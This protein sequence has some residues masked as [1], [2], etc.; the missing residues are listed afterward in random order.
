ML[1]LPLTSE[2]SKNLIEDML[3]HPQSAE[4]NEHE[5]AGYD[6]ANTYVVRVG[7][8]P[9][10]FYPTS[11]QNIPAEKSVKMPFADASRLAASLN[12][13]RMDRAQRSES[14]RNEHWHIIC[15]ARRGFIVSR[16]HVPPYWEPNSEYDLPPMPIAGPIDRKEAFK[17][18]KS[19]NTWELANAVKPRKWAII[20]NKPEPDQ[21]D[22]IL[23][24]LP[25]GL[26]HD[27]SE[28]IQ[29]PVHRDQ[30]RELHLISEGL[31]VSVPELV[32]AL[33]SRFVGTG[34]G[35]HDVDYRRP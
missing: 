12:R 22:S 24:D 18:I 1:T 30:F 26:N 33:I 14:T 6:P 7:I 15:G 31:S 21:S 25:I 5:H 13:H 29:V 20:V 35:W 10:E 4:P 19:I 34:K 23:S 32:Q 8:N 28:L 16:I 27:E 9:S 11:P 17:V 2:K 3:D